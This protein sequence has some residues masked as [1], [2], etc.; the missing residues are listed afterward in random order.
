MKLMINNQMAN[1]Q[2]MN[3]ME[4]ILYLLLLN[5]PET[6]HSQVKATL[7]L[8]AGPLESQINMQ[9]ISPSLHSLTNKSVSTVSRRVIV[10]QM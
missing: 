1:K 10:K 4:N 9:P 2:V 5:V 3:E 7:D 6:A 8:I